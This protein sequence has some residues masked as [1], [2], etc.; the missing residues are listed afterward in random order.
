M[1][2]THAFSTT[3]HPNYRDVARFTKVVKL[4]GFKPFVSAANALEQINAISDGICTDDLKM[5]LEQNLPR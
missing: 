4:Q 1:P 2:L 3:T 5:F